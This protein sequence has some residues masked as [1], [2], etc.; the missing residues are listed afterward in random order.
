MILRKMRKSDIDNYI[1]C[2][3]RIWETLR[4]Y[5]PQEYVDTNLTWIRRQGV[6]DAWASCIDSP[7]WI[8]PV[9]V[10]GNSIVG[11]ARGQVDWSHLST[12]GFLGVDE[13]YRRKGIARRLMEE[14][15]KNSKN[16]GASKIT[17]DTSPTLK[18]AV[19]L[20]TDMGFIPEGFLRRHRLGVDLI[21]FSKF[22]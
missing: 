4:D 14:F 12:L 8:L 2:E 22:L 5:L 19:K 20:Y 16:L 7:N 1:D 15:I 13:R 17:L 21:V 3:E 6:E 11:M 18:P 9:V 10:D